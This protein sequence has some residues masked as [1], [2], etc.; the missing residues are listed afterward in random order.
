M[1]GQILFSTSQLFIASAQTECLI[2]A[3]LSK[4]AQF[5]NFHDLYPYK[6]LLLIARVMAEIK[7][8]DLKFCDINP[9]ALDLFITICSLP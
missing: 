5:P 8:C 4:I 2:L 6:I 9:K 3:S 7:S 1:L